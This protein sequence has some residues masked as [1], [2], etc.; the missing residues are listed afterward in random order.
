M[1]NK[2]EL[3]VNQ[4]LK[5]YGAIREMQLLSI[6]DIKAKVLDEQ[7][8]KLRSKK[9]VLCVAG[10]IKAGKS[11]LLNA[12]VFGK[13]V[14]PAHGTPH[15]AKI[16][17][18]SYSE[19]EHFNVVFYSEEEWDE[20]R[21]LPEKNAQGIDE[22]GLYF[23]TY[24]ADDVHALAQKDIHPYDYF[25]KIINVD[26]LSQLAQYVAINGQFTPFVKNVSIGYPNSVLK[27]LVIVDTPGTNDPNVFRSKMT[28]EWIHKADAVIYA[29]YVG[30]PLDKN[31]F[32]FIDKYLLHVSPSKRIVAM[33]KI[34]LSDS[35][36]DVKKYVNSLKSKSEFQ[37]RIF[38][39]QTSFVYISALGALIDR[40]LLNG[41]ELSDALNEEAIR[42]EVKGYLDENKHGMKQLQET[43][44]EKLIQNKVA[45]LLQ[46]HEKYIDSLFVRKS[47]EID[48][49]LQDAKGSLDISLSSTQDNE[50]R[51]KNIKRALADMAQISNEF[52]GNLREEQS[53]FANK[54]D[55]GISSVRQSIETAIEASLSNIQNIKE[56][57]NIQWHIKNSLDREFGKLLEECQKH[58]KDL[59]S[60]IEGSIEKLQDKLLSFK[61]LNDEQIRSLIRF[62]SQVDIDSMRER[63]SE[64]FDTANV[65]QM[66]HDNTNVFERFFNMRSGRRDVKIALE[67]QVKQELESLI[68]MQIKSRI[69]NEV[70]NGIDTVRQSIE[71]QVNISLKK[72]KTEI[73]SLESEKKFDQNQIDKLKSKIETMKLEQN[74]I[75][76]KKQRVETILNSEA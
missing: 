4:L 22:S 21:Q 10:Q 60:N 17:E 31:D 68:N 70:K 59:N 73:E 37:E 38:N 66:I 49:D 56:Y 13:E 19:K 69:V 58:E 50:I 5:A 39:E 24:I 14:L 6:A 57:S 47:Q 64:V 12:L 26:D 18:M 20:L 8:E 53:K 15:T 51:L 48:V 32:E 16:T 27:H 67:N 54:I 44:D 71:R 36:D 34:D 65:Q 25:G 9:F 30:R 63:I 28:E 41:I 61:V 3:R 46:S 76:I 29:S 2:Y 7:E 42:L 33:T 43:I 45:S 55:L 23:K 1:L 72:S 74:E 52:T 40:M 62:A 35:V 75:D 11:T